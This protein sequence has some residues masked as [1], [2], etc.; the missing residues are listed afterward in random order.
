M[1][2]RPLSLWRDMVK[3]MPNK[4]VVDAN[5]KNI[6]KTDEQDI[7]RVNIEILSSKPV[8]GYADFTSRFVG[9]IVEAKLFA[10]EG[11]SITLNK[12]VKLTIRYE[13]DER[14]GTFFAQERSRQTDDD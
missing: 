7:F 5:I 2:I 9:R 6:K 3:V 8:E 12:P 13:G 4:A 10:P 11:D 14:G 1:N